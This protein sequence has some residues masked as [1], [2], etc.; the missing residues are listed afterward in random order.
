MEALIAKID[1]WDAQ[2]TIKKPL[3]LERLQ[4]SSVRDF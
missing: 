3:V 2:R 1:V 4:H